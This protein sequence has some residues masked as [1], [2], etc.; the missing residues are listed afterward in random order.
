MLGRARLHG[1]DAFVQILWPETFAHPAAATSSA[2][3]PSSATPNFSFEA[4]CQATV[5]EDT[6]AALASEVGLTSDAASPWGWISGIP[7][8]RH[9]RSGKLGLD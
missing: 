3:V 6:A 2:V 8:C 5:S 4:S 7:Q 9:E 1:P